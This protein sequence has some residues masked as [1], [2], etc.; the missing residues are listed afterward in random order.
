LTNDHGQT[1]GRRVARAQSPIDAVVIGDG[2]M[3]QAALG[4]RARDLLRAAQRIE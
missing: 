3:S 2:E 1:L 4:G